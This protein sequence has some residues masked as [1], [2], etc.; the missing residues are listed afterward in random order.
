MTIVGIGVD[1]VETARLAQSIERHGDRFLDRL[2]TADERRYCDAQSVPARCYAARFAAKEAVSKAFGTGIGADIEWLDIV[3]LRSPEGKP[4]IELRGAG[5]RL[6]ERIGVSD[7][8]LSMSHSDHYAVA[9][10]VACGA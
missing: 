5:R 4:S 1:I 3:V 6:A 9:Q 8:M 2:F 7:V 10:V